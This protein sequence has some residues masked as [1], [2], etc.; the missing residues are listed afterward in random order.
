VAAVIHSIAKHHK[1]IILSQG[2]ELTFVI[3]RD[4]TAKK[5]VPPSA[6]MPANQ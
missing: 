1:D 5:V 3:S 4:V 2:T 6:A